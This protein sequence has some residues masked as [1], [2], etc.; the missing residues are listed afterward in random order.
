MGIALGWNPG[1]RGEKPP[2]NRPSYGT[3]CKR[4]LLL[5]TKRVSLTREY[6]SA[7]GGARAI[8]SCPKP[9]VCQP[10]II[11]F[12]FV[13]CTFPSLIQVDAVQ[14]RSQARV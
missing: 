10:T 5:V 1:L 8:E 12:C 14:K 3:V 6:K 9:F 7:A 13:G 4:T 2:T 11:I